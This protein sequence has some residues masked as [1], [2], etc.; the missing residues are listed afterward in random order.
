[1]TLADRGHA[2]PGQTARGG[3][4]APPRAPDGD[5]ARPQGRPAARAVPPVRERR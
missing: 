1:M 4:L 5:T 3:A 2:A